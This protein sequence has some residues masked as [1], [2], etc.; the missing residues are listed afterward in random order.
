MKAKSFC[1]S[2]FTFHMD[3]AVLPALALSHLVGKD[4]RTAERLLERFFLDLLMMAQDTYGT[5]IQQSPKPPEFLVKADENLSTHL[6]EAFS[7]VTCSI[8]LISSNPALVSL[9]R[10][11]LPSK[12]VTLQV[13][14][15]LEGLHR[16]PP[17]ALVLIDALNHDWNGSIPFLQGLDHLVVRTLVDAKR[18][19]MTDARLQDQVIPV[20]V[21]PR[22]GV[23][24]RQAA[25]KG[26]LK[27]ALETAQF[28]RYFDRCQASHLRWRTH[29]EMDFRAG[30]P[31]VKATLC[32]EGE[33][34]VLR[35]QDL[36]RDIPWGVVPSVRF[37]DVLGQESTKA[38][39][40]GFLDWLK[41]PHG[42]PGLRACVLSGP[43]GTGKTHACEATAGEAG[44]PCILMGGSEFLTQW[45][46][47]SERI[48]RETFASLQQYDAAVLVV[49]EFDAIAWARGQSNEWSAAYQSS[50]VGTMLRSIDLLR[51]GPGRVLLLAT[52]NQYE[53]IDPAIVRSM[54]MGEHIHV[55]LPTAKDRHAILQGL[56]KGLADDP[57]ITE[58]VAM[59]TGLSPA[60]LVQLVD[61]LK[62]AGAVT[63]EG[64][65]SPQLTAALFDLRRGEVDSGRQLNS[66]AKRRVAYHEAGHA[67]LAYHL[68]GPV[69][70]E[71]LT[72]IPTV[73]GGLGAAYMHQSESLDL[74]DADFIKKRLAVLLGGRVAEALS[75]PGSGPSCGAENDIKEATSLAQLA[76][77]TWGLDPEFPMVSLDALTPSLQQALAPKL[78]ERIQVW[79]KAAEARA[80]E[81]LTRHQASLEFLVR[82]LVTAETLHRS[83]ILAILTQA[84]PASAESNSESPSCCS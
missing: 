42:E 68:L 79:L 20:I 18:S 11:L 57:A 48:I 69:S 61:R 63:S 12:Q 6:Q 45:Y 2:G 80:L 19:Q 78:L 67:L 3:G 33:D 37:R 54:R 32:F 29:L 23:I 58:A 55:G 41:D 73:S 56:L 66:V 28:S 40:Q 83:D 49:D 43:P 84:G 38:R 35:S 76:V 16:L 65:S 22:K 8:H 1:H 27:N 30:D 24:R 9:V 64:L 7:E 82:H 13:V 50:I 71:H 10:R 46:G 17:G 21:H 39:L 60:D 70:V 53:R 44:V 31:Y 72:V 81:E 47:E 5:A 14:A 36:K 4:L 77:G 59:T 15:T 74:P 25:A 51:K 26:L 34:R 62:R 75:Y 52:T